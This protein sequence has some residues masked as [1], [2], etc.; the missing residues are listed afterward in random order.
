MRFGWFLL[1]MTKNGPKCFT[2]FHRLKGQS[3]EQEAQPLQCSVFF[4]S[5]PHEQVPFPDRK[6]QMATTTIARTTN[7]TMTVG[8]FMR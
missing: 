8:Q 4:P 5:L 6:T 1:Y 2:D 7:S 3:A